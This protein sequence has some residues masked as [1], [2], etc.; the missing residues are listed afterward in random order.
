MDVFE[1]EKYEFI[2]AIINTEV[3]CPWFPT[4][5]HLDIADAVDLTLV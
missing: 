4:N 2:L 5:K 1:W 3:T